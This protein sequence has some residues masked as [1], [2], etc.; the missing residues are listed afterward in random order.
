[1][2]G[3]CKERKLNFEL[4]WSE[5]RVSQDKGTAKEGDGQEGKEEKLMDKG[6]KV[7]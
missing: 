5:Q 4:R 7:M 6:E 3:R 2:K 1:M